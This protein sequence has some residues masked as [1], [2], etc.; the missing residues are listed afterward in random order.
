M[1]GDPAFDDDLA[2]RLP[3]PLAQLYRR[4]HNAKTPLDRHHAAYCL[5]EAALKLLGRRRSSPTPSAAT[6]DAEAGRAAAEPGPAGAG[7][8]VG[9]R[10]PARARRWPTPATRASASVRELVLG[11]QRD[12]LP[13][14]AGLDAALREALDG[15][16]GARVTVRLS[17]LFDRLVRYR[18]RELG[19]G[20]AG[21]AR[22]RVLRA[23]GPGH[24]ARGGRAAR[25]A[26]RAGRPPPGLPSPTSAARRRA[27]GWSSGYELTGRNAPAARI[28]GTARV[29]GRPAAPPG[30][31]L[32]RRAADAADRA[33]WSLHPLVLFEPRRRRSSS[34]TPA[35][36]GGGPS[37]SATAPAGPSSGTD[38]GGEQR[39]LL[40]QRPGRRGRRRPGRAMGGAVAGRGAAVR[41]R[42]EDRRGAGWAS[43]SC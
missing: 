10:P 26:R 24:A 29:G 1:G 15:T 32:P 37:T 36:A 25:P 42:P 23:D 14:A 40:A 6:P 16:G 13:R 34:S 39:A 27:P 11:R 43:S 8:L 9:V 17:E 3:L 20:A 19:H 41:R 30:A 35:A 33:A 7:A 21:P 28:A 5:W 12:D 2:R 22:R 31:A 18:N 38:L 4:A